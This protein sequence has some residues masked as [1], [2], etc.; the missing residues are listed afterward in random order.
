MTN[1]AMRRTALNASI[2][3]PLA[4]VCAYA[5]SPYVS[6]YRMGQAVHRGDLA[7]LCADVS[8]NEVREGLKEDIADGMTGETASTQLASNNDDLPAFGSSFVTSMAGNV[9]DRT[10]NPEHLAEALGTLHAAGTTAAPHIV[11]A[12]FTTPTSF[13]VA[14]RTRQERATDAPVRLRLV[15]G[16]GPGGIGWRVTRAWVPEALLTQ[17]D[18]HTS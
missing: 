15:L 4:A 5:A 7:T 3:L 6:L 12:F 10:V 1:R 9:V 14:F 17:S 13:E 8:W 18:T 11:S 16:K 2:A